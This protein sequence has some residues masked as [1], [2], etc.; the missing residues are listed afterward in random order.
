MER[1]IKGHRIKRML[2]VLAVGAGIF[3]AVSTSLILGVYAD[4]PG[5]GNG[6]GGGGANGGSCSGTGNRQD[7][8]FGATWRYETA[9]SD[10]IQI[11]GSAHVSGG[12]ITGCQTYGGHYYRL[13]LERYNVETYNSTHD[14]TQASQ[15]YQVGL[16]PV[17]DIV[18]SA[19]VGGSGY[20]NFQVIG[21]SKASK[22]W[23]EVKAQFDAAKAYA[24]S[25]PGFGGNL[26]DQSWEDTSWFCWKEGGIDPTSVES[27]FG[28]WSSAVAKDTANNTKLTVNTSSIDSN[29]EGTIT[30]N[31][32]TI[33]ID[34]KH[35]F[36]YEKP[37]SGSGDFGPA[38]TKYNVNV[39]NGGAVTNIVPDGTSYVVDSPNSGPNRPIEPN[40]P[41][42]V[43]TSTQTVNVPPNPGESVRV[44]SKIAYDPKVIAWKAKSGGG[45][46]MDSA[47]SKDSAS[48]EVCVNIKRGDGTTVEEEDG[49]RIRFWSDSTIQVDASESGLGTI[50]ETTEKEA[51]DDTVTVSI[52]TDNDS[53][54]ATFWHTLHW[55]HESRDGGTID[56][57]I[58]T[59][60]DEGLDDLKTA[61]NITHDGDGNGHQDGSGD[62]AVKDYDEYQDSDYGVE[63]KMTPAKQ[64]Q[65]VTI[66]VSPGE[67]KKFCS[68]IDYNPEIINLMRSYEMEEYVITP[69]QPIWGPTP[70]GWGIIGTIPP[71]TG[72]R[73]KDGGKVTYRADG[74]EGDGYSEACIEVTH[75][76][77]DNPAPQPDHGASSGDDNTE[78]MYA[79][80][81]TT[82]SWNIDATGYETRRLLGFQASLF[83]VK[84]G[85]AF[86]ADKL[87]GDLNNRTDTD[88]C[89]WFSAKN[90]L[91]YNCRVVDE[92]SYGGSNP[93]GYAGNMPEAGG[94]NPVVDNL[95]G[96]KYCNSAGYHWQYWVKI[97]HTSPASEEW[98]GGKKYWTHY[99]AAC[100]TIVKKPSFS[101]WNGGVFATGDITTS[102]A[103]RNNPGTFGSTAG[104]KK[105]F[106][107]WTEYL[108]VPTGV[109]N[110]FSSGAS[111]A[112][113][114]FGG[115]INNPLRAMSPLTISNNTDVM[116]NSGVSVSS[117]T[118]DRLKSYFYNNSSAENQPG[119][120]NTS[121]MGLNGVANTRIIKVG[122]NLNIDSNITLAN[123]GGSIY[124]L[125][126]VVLY[127]TGNINITSNV[128]RVDAW[129]IA[130]GEVNTC[131]NFQTGTTEAHVPEWNS[132]PACS[133]RLMINGPIFTKKLITNRSYGAD[134]FSNSD[135]YYRDQGDN[136]DSRAESGEVFNLS[137]ENYLWAYAHAGRY[138][139][140]FSEAYSR[141][142]PPRY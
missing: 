77:N 42:T 46:E 49:G 112:W 10:S 74:T 99:D 86:S 80:E 83:Q 107:S 43:G 105:N 90:D 39:T 38:T 27:T 3:G 47:E 66:N 140:S 1:K 104:N 117:S 54:E 18:S 126:Q 40:E 17:K 19:G 31:E 113:N 103:P 84:V 52:S 65:T 25:H 123:T 51:T 7:T 96:D 13:A 135:T 121:S 67:T 5:G 76:S 9:S 32:D 139:S 4:D 35:R 94:D 102:L 33:I 37:T 75:P 73:K 62:Y 61:Y 55:V 124:E 132:N 71:V 134:G 137:A 129:L 6:G 11:S 106:G 127:A 36:R 136:G 87:K 30:T 69:A 64:T 34:F 82:I 97:T 125:P 85:Q 119:G 2:T 15:G 115:V 44:C 45:Y 131:I 111:L 72:Q 28:V 122:G 141:E 58:D 63:D 114:G 81:D 79:G 53:I 57:K 26:K 128:T 108:A 16:M 95:V 59:T 41:N 138:G 8:C 88:V 100:R 118:A 56:P 60:K 50:K 78:F 12:T 133:A 23:S 101:V 98:R 110:G 89:A 48:S 20:V 91:R 93:D 24:A 68:K 116:G 29:N 109:I 22:S 70:W 120:S 130:E 21:G 142:L 14:A 92:A